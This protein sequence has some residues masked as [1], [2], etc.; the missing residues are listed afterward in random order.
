VIG[1]KVCRSASGDEPTAVLA[2]FASFAEFERDHQ[3]GPLGTR[4]CAAVHNE[5]ALP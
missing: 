4:P 3:F 1:P 5:T 2:W